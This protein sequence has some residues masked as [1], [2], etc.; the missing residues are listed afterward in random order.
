MRCEAAA[1]GISSSSVVPAKE[2][3]PSS[4]TNRT[5]P[6]L[7]HQ[8]EKVFYREAIFFSALELKQLLHD[9]GFTNR[10]WVH[11]LTK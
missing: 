3:Q 7:A 2:G 9:T 1:R 5:A 4:R 11:A 8:T 10:A 6:H